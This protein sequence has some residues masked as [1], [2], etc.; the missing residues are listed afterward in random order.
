MH[1]AYIV[2]FT[3]STFRAVTLDMVEDNTSKNFVD[4]MK[5]FIVRRG[6]P[7]NIVS[8]N[9]KVVTSLEN[10]SFCAEQGMT[11]NYN[12]DGAPWCGGFWKR[13]SY[14]MVKSCIKKLI[15]RKS[16][17]LQSC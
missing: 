8:D 9:G 16:C 14:G 3:C 1:K 15:G 13:V 7:K 4:S 11:W 6:C 17:R 2:S 12:L 10:Q 5:K